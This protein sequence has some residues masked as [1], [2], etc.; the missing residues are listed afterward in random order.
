MSQVSEEQ[1]LASGV[2]ELVARLREEGVTAGLNEAKTILA[3]ARHEAKHI[4]E[5]ANADAHQR[6]EVARKEAEAFRDAGIA[7][8]KTAMRDMVLDMKATL[9]EGFGA[10]VKRLVSHQLQDPQVLKQMILELAAR[11]RDD[12]NMGK[13]G[14][15]EFI[16][17]ETVIGLEELRSNPEALQEGPLTEFVFGLTREMLQEGISFAVSADMPRG[18]RVQLNDTNVVIDLTEQTVAQLLLQH[19]QPRFRAIL[20][21]VVK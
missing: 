5:K 17:P 13:V 8:L 15:V 10:D 3:D 16:L 19:L 6:L 14:S 7:A 1:R 9:T 11:A 20:E 2:D 21:G 4:L 18:I 12:I